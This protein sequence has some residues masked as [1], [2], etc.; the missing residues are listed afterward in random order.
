MVKQ[1]I[2]SVKKKLRSCRAH[3]KELLAVSDDVYNIHH[4]YIVRPCP[5]SLSV[6]LVQNRR[7]IQAIDILFY[8]SFHTGLAAAS[9]QSDSNFFCV[10]FPIFTRQACFVCSTTDRVDGV[11]IRQEIMWLN[12]AKIII[13]SRKSTWPTLKKH[14]R[15][16]M[17]AKI[18]S[19]FER[20][21]E[22]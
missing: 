8:F 20:K 12:Y 17:I 7:V 6:S 13:S 10:N 15:D 18:N 4:Q 22:G 11:S 1:Y 21:T 3:R 2:P 5:L 14:K 16:R 9:G 19:A